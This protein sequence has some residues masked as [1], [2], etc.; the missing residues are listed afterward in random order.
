MTES[1]QISA[2]LERCNRY[3]AY[4]NNMLAETM[5]TR[6]G[7]PDR[8]DTYRLLGAAV[9]DRHRLVFNTYARSAIRPPSGQASKFA[10]VGGAVSSILPDAEHCV[11]GGLYEVGAAALAALDAAE[12]YP[13]HYDR[14]I[15][16]VRLRDDADEYRAWV[17]VAVAPQDENRA[18]P[19]YLA[20]LRAG[21]EELELPHAYQSFLAS[22]VEP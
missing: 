11:W 10:Q 16:T 8:S 19:A 7:E 5:R 20:R 18:V 3:F 4:G 21:A 6:C 17:Y 1:S 2:D 14:S 12:G 13:H 9:L 15:M 22:C